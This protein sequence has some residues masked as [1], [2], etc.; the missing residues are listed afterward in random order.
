MKALKKYHN[1]RDFLKLS[2]SNQKQIVR[3]F[4]S[5]ARYTERNS[6]T[7]CTK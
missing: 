1:G 2:A 5:R 3:L 4:V 6:V 7:I